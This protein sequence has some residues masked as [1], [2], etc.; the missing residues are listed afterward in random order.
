MVRPVAS[1]RVESVR[2]IPLLLAFA[3]ALI[4]AVGPVVVNATGAA[5][6]ACGYYVAVTGNDR[7]N[8]TSPTTP[9][10]TLEKAQ[11]AMRSSNSKIVCLRAGTFNRTAP[12]KL[13]SADNGQTWRY[14]PQD[15][16]NTAILDGAGKI[17]L[18]AINGGSHITINGL[19][20]QNFYAFGIIGDSTTG[21]TTGNTIENCDV[22]FNVVTSWHSAAIVMGNVAP[23]T[24]ITNNYVHDV[25]SQGIAMF[26]YNSPRDNI[27]GTVISGNVVLRAVQRMSDGGAI[28]VS[29]H[30]GTQHSRV[31]VTNN[32]V[33]DYG[34][35]G[36]DAA[37]GIYLD[38]NAN[39]ILISGNVV[40]PPRRG[41]T[42][43]QGFLVHNG[44][45]IEI[46]GNI[47]DLG[48]SAT[49]W[50]G[51]WSGEIAN[52]A[53][54]MAGNSFTGNIVISNFSA[55]QK[56][57]WG[58]SGFSFDQNMPPGS[59]YRIQHNLYHNYGGGQ[60]RSDG[61][62][63]SDSN[64]IYV[65]PQISGWTYQLGRTSPAYRAPVNFTPIAGGWGPP[66]FTIPQNGA[67]PSSPH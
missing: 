48:D 12:L 15:G 1:G 58:T 25:G 27:D 64:A 24:R 20:L 9:F 37:R 10:A 63:A 51:A 34:A 55:E 5:P 33:R 44:H 45:D 50:V 41:A 31:A 46:R 28:Y 47:F 3:L 21:S 29:M 17:D 53:A 2:L 23:N 18:I 14:D 62:L 4:A 39:N 65:D 67:A 19:K 36:V 60:V 35:P 42:H 32:F 54:G 11:S 26:A 56:T 40:A 61:A 57:H 6:S 59:N 8:G 38:D 43:Q 66:G 7:N 22:G 30:G 13:T 16:V 52:V 49:C